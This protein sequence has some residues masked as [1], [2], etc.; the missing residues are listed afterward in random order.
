VAAPPGSYYLVV[1]RTT[2]QGPVPSVARMVRVGTASDAGEA[3]QPF[4]DDVSAPDG[5][6]TPDADSSAAA[7][8][9]QQAGEAARTAPATPV[10]PQLPGRRRQGLAWAVERR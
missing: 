8:T 4:P 5:S 10:G 9:M 1:N 7:T 3:L 6:A 2:D